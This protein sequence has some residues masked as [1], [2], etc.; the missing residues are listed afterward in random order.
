MLSPTPNEHIDYHK[1]VV[2]AREILAQID[3]AERGYYRLGQLVYEVAEAAE[4]GDRTLA[5]FADDVGVAKCT[6]DRY[7]NVYR[8]WKD[9]LAPGPKLPSYSVLRELAPH[10]TEPEVAKTVQD[11]PNITKR[12]A[13]DIKRKLKRAANEKQKQDQEAAWLKE[14]RR[15]FRELYNHAEEA[16]R[17]AYA[18]LDC[19]PEKQ[20]ELLQAVDSLMLGNLRGY[21]RAL[22]AFCDHYAQLAERA[23]AKQEEPEKVEAPI[24]RARHAETVTGH[25][26]AYDACPARSGPLV[27]SHLESGRRV[28]PRLARMCA[29]LR[30]AGGGH[31]DVALRRIGGGPQ[32]RLRCEG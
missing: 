8:S 1:A 14:N 30:A 10:A 26:M 27:G 17:V 25:A 29:L 3:A 31:E 19:T 2:A 28:L 12:E 22:L 13:L 15:G 16:S 32:R 5:R 9:K 24:E 7:A 11:D 21:A 4:Y 6:L 20:L 18:W 23:A